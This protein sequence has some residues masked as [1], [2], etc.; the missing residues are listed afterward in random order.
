MG[1][2]SSGRTAHTQEHSLFVFYLQYFIKSNEQTTTANNLGL[3]QILENSAVLQSQPPSRNATCKSFYFRTM[4]YTV[5]I[6]SLLCYKHKLTTREVGEIQPTTLTE[7]PCR[8]NGGWSALIP[9]LSSLGYLTYNM[10]NLVCVLSF[11]RFRGCRLLHTFQ[12]LSL[13][14]LSHYIHI[15]YDYLPKISFVNS[16]CWNFVCPQSPIN[17]ILTVRH[18][19]VS[20]VWNGR[21]L[22]W[23]RLTD[24]T[25]LISGIV[26][27]LVHDLWKFH[28]WQ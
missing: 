4:W 12:Y 26:D 20:L 3:E 24:V 13:P 10:F 25:V 14:T 22:P 18:A 1:F 27:A 28:Y 2:E 7:S 5:W 17:Y 19:S 9:Q 21:P 23:W 15:A 11:S 16:V 6:E 8:L